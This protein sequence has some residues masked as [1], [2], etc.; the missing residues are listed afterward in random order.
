MAPL[1]PM[2]CGE[3]VQGIVWPAY[4]QLSFYRSAA[5]RLPPWNQAGLPTLYGSVPAPCTDVPFPQFLRAAVPAGCRDS[6]SATDVSLPA[7]FEWQLLTPLDIYRLI[8]LSLGLCIQCN[9]IGHIVLRF[10]F[11]HSWLPICQRTQRQKGQRCHFRLPRIPH[12]ATHRRFSSACRIS[13]TSKWQPV[14]AIG[15]AME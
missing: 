9:P 3:H 2:S 12:S 1:S 13:A 6:R 15:S 7:L 8:C 11:C 14:H 10:L 4:R 5:G